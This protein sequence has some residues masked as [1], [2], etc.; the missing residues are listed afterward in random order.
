MKVAINGFGR[1]GKLVFRAFLQKKIPNV[2]IIAINE[3]GSLD[4]SY[5]LLQFD[6][7]HGPLPIEIKKTK[8]GLKYKNKSIIFFA[9][10]DPNKLPWKKMKIDIV[11]ECSGIFT[12]KEKAMAHIK[13][14]AKKVII[15]APGKNV[16]A[17]IVQGVNNHLVSK[18]HTIISN[19]SCTTN[20]LAP[21]AMVLDNGV[22]IENGFMTTIHSYTGDQRTLDQAHTDLRRSRAAASSMIPTSTGAASALSLV[23]PNLKGK[24]DGTAIRVPTP[25]VSLIDLTFVSKKKTN[26]D[27]INKLIIKASKTKSLKNILTVNSLPLVSIDFNHNPSSSI[28]DLT[29]TQVLNN[30]FCRVLSWYD[31]EW[32][33]SNRMIDTMIDLKKYI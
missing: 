2:E 14:G 7:S 11:L 13:A 33:F 16:D 25:N 8:N 32:G 19:G 6:S 4:S 27:A 10:K 24:L 18:K 5:H 22:G 3:L 23:L 21:V 15:S 9:E 26:V 31:N 1:I 28:F 20:C 30:K 12:S 29:Q 17:T